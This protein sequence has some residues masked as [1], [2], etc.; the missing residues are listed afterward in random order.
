MT[1]QPSARTV[2]CGGAIVTVT[3]DTYQATQR[4]LD[5]DLDVP[6]LPA[7]GSKVEARVV[8]GAEVLQA[9]GVSGKGVQYAT[10]ARCAGIEA[11]VRRALAEMAA[12]SGR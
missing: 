1:G 12:R 11:T 6:S 8:C 7:D 4:D 10:C 9:T 5:V 2:R 3:R